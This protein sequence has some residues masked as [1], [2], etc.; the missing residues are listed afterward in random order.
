MHGVETP[1]CDV[2]TT[3]Q[4]SNSTNGKPQITQI[5]TDSRQ[6]YTRTGIDSNAQCRDATV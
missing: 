4:E 3:G 5:D 1:Q 6:K 2:S